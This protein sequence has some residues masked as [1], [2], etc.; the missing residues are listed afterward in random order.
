VFVSNVCV[1]RPG[2]RVTSLLGRVA[3]FRL[4]GATS[5]SLLQST[6]EPAQL[7]IEPVQKPPQPAVSAPTPMTGAA[8]WR[9]L[10]GM[11]SSAS[12]VA[13]AALSM[14]C[15]DPRTTDSRAAAT[16]G[17]PGA[18]ASIGAAAGGA[19]VG[20]GGGASATATTATAMSGG[21]RVDDPV[22]G[23]DVCRVWPSAMDD[24]DFLWSD[25]CHAT[26]MNA[27]YVCAACCCHC[28]SVLA[29]VDLLMVCCGVMRCCSMSEHYINAS[30]RLSVAAVATHDL[31]HLSGGGGG[32]GHRQSLTAKLAH[33]QFPC[34]V[35][36]QPSLQA[37][38]FAAGW[39]VIVPAC[40]ARSLWNALVFRGASAVRVARCCAV[41]RGVTSRRK[42]VTL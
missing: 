13:G 25:S 26:E 12:V 34:V 36:Q 24:A 42:T 3:R 29:I 8:L 22:S 19:G 10:G 23:D 11:K 14:R 35:V 27:L 41:L 16:R 17:R 2:V 28:T 31:E 5:H 21:K 15:F 40:W 33:S 6:L 4:L 9:R 20:S 37:G 1:C 39:D 32:G 38:A 18:A 30:K 7:P